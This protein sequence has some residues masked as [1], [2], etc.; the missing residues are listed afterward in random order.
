MEIVL[1]VYIL[2][3]LK[4]KIIQLDAKK[5]GVLWVNK[6]ICDSGKFT[7][8]TPNLKWPKLKIYGK[9]HNILVMNFDLRGQIWTLRQK[10]IIQTP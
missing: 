1:F 9:K 4:N 7:E 5:L 6:S 8:S 10:W 3:V 2:S